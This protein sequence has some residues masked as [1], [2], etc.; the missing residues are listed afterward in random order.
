MATS[1]RV[2]MTGAQYNGAANAKTA[3][4]QIRPLHAAIY[5][6][7]NTAKSLIVAVEDLERRLATV[8]GGVSALT[9]A[10]AP[11]APRPPCSNTTAMIEDVESIVRSAVQRIR[12]LLDTLEV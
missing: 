10:A 1:E 4:E 12:Q 2:Q 9:G 5:E 7:D 11:T 6:A 3:S 8:C